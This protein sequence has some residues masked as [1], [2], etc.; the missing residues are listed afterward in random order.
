[1]VSL[2]IAFLNSW[3]TTVS[4]GSGTAEGIAG[5]AAGLRSLGH[6]VEI[7]SPRPGPG[8]FTL[9]RLLFNLRAHRRLAACAPFDLIVGFDIDGAFLGARACPP[10]VVCL[11]GIAADEARFARGLDRL[12]L[13]FLAG[14]ERRNAHSARCVVVPS[15]YSAEVA[16][17]RYGLSRDS[18]RVVPEP[19]D[20]AV[21]EALRADPP[22]RGP[23]PTILSV[24]RQYPRKDTASLLRAF[25]I[26]LRRIPGAQLRII[27][28][29]PELPRLKVLA[30]QL[31]IA[32]SV[33]FEGAV[34][35]SDLVRRAYLESDVFCLPSLQEGF[36]IV[37]LEAMA[38]GL[39]VVA[40]RAGATPE[41][42]EDGVTGI[43]VPP[44]G[45]S[46]LADALTLLLRDPQRARSMGRA[47]IA[48]VRDFDR[49]AVAARFL[50]AVGLG[51]PGR[52]LTPASSLSSLPVR[53]TESS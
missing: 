22:P 48:R 27:G 30:R 34:P 18:L 47:G 20:L 37:F 52:A 42:V 39:P 7:I 11:K 26:V 2:R 40:A 4:E 45:A 16:T 21:W 23:E 24:A 14:L 13:R 9:R 8:P 53:G 41:V 12:H 25:A 10:H 33:H 36:G 35:G 38:A 28:G 32:S 3:K 5:L 44:R 46:A 51:E 17:E 31:S 6:S 15:A 19:L 43:L 1:M 50:G 49:T 29:G